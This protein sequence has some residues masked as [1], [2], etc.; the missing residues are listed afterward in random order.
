[1]RFSWIGGRILRCF[2]EEFWDD[3][4]QNEALIVVA[5]IAAL[6]GVFNALLVMVLRDDVQRVHLLINSGMRS[7]DNAMKAEGRQQERDSRGS[8]DSSDK[9]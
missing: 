7:R 1:M 8:G 5:V 4:T 6:P 9:E 2:K 3:V